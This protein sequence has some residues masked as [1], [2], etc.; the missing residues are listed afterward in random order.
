DAK[1]VS[2]PAFIRLACDRHQWLKRGR[3]R[4]R[5]ILS[6]TRTMI[7]LWPSIY[8]PSHAPISSWSFLRPIFSTPHSS[9]ASLQKGGGGGGGRVRQLLRKPGKTR[10]WAGLLFG[11]GTGLMG[12]LNGPGKNMAEKKVPA[13]AGFILDNGG[14]SGFES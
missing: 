13:E 12:I 6:I 4:C 1:E 14:S 2:S 9:G 8:T 3:K 10:T 7:S 11:F 5:F